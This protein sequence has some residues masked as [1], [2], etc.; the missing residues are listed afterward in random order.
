MME[1]YRTDLIQTAFEF[2]DSFILDLGDKWLNNIKDEE[3]KSGNKRV[4]SV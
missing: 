2:H 3:I 1:L 4:D